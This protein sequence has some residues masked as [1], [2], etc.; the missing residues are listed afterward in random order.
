MVEP[1]CPPN[2]ERSRIFSHPSLDFEG[3][4]P[5]AIAKVEPDVEEREA[6]Q[7]VPLPLAHVNRF[8]LQGRFL[9]VCEAGEDVAPESDRD[10]LP[11]KRPAREAGAVVD[12]HRFASKTETGDFP[13]ARIS[14]LRSRRNASA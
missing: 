8:V 1:A 4:P 14:P 6:N 11:G 7:S 2:G 13:S 12:F 3:I 10:V 5:I 9:E